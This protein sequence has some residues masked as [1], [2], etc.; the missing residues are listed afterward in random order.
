M[1]IIVISGNHPRNLGLP[2]KLFENKKTEI[3]GLVLY[4]REDI[5][6]KPD[7]SLDENLK[8]LWEIHFKKRFESEK[9][10]FNFD[11][12]FINNI[13]NKLIVNNEKEL[14]SNKILDLINSVKADACFIQGIPIIKDP[15]LSAL[16][17]Y[18]I[19]LHLGIIPHYKG[20]ITVFWPFYFL[21]PS[22]V[23]TTYHIIDRYVDTG[24]IIHQNVPKLNYG[25]SMHDVSCKALIAAL[26]DIDIVVDEIIARVKTKRKINKDSSL[27]TKGRLFK[28]SDWKPEML[29][30][31]YNQYN[32]RIVDMYLDGKIKSSK[33]ELI[34]VSRS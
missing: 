31:I 13:K 7:I 4:K 1:K 26:D 24:E 32:D 23:G 16:P 18:T 3:V 27:K 12:N 17:N 33:P 10:F 20:A 8:K 9:K 30:K 14:N 5:I 28:T 19:N 11:V 22:M 34:K 2:K 15:V 6:P 29:K 25:D 21:E